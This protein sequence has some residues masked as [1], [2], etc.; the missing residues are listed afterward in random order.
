MLQEWK[1]K[2][3]LADCLRTAQPQYD[4]MKK[5]IMHGVICFS[6]TD[7]PVRI[8]KVGTLQTC[9]NPCGDPCA[10]PVCSAWA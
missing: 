8:M 3:G 5:A 2:N 6:K 7:H 4:A 10:R 1:Q 9:I